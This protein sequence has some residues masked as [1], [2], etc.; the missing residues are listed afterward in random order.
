MVN[1]GDKVRDKIG[2]FEGICI[3]R[4]EY[5]YGCVQVMVAPTKLAKEGKRADSEWFDEGRVEVVKRNA[6][7]R[8]ASAAERA[9]GPLTEPAPARR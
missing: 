9:G 1:L 5:L 8:P 7:P 3:G 6:Q 4:G 2:G